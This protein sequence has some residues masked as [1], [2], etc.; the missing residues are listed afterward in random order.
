[1]LRLIRSGFFTTPNQ[2]PPGAVTPQRLTRQ[3]EIELFPPLEEGMPEEGLFRQAVTHPGAEAFRPPFP[4]TGASFVDGKRLERREGRVLFVR[5]GQLRQSQ[6]PFCCRFVHM[7]AEEGDQA[8]LAP[9]LEAIPP[10]MDF[11]DPQRLACL[12]DDLI[13]ADAAPAPGQELFLHAKLTELVSLLYNNAQRY[14]Q[15]APVRQE[16]FAAEAYIRSH[17]AQPLSLEELAA[18]TRYS[19]S[20]LHKLF[21]AALGR[22]PAQYLTD[23]RIAQAKRM[24]LGTSLPAARIAEACGFESPSYFCYVF[25]RETGLT[26][27]AYR[28]EGQGAIL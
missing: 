21:K 8:L 11:F 19:P 23:C 2:Y 1:M 9:Y 18:R 4:S 26:P 5:P 7:E 6:V 22:T 16:V 14:R 25:R 17:L 13:R 10:M 12:L 20:H 3:Y 15:P 28:R 27:S 24:L